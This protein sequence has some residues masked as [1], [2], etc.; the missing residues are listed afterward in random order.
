M[1]NTAERIL[2]ELLENLLIRSALG[3]NIIP[4]PPHLAGKAPH[5][6][7]S[8]RVDYCYYHTRTSLKQRWLLTRDPAAHAQPIRH[9][10]ENKCCRT[11]QY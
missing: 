7:V 9:D 6:T 1:R 2:I 5:H 4:P 3:G 8:Y 10:F 11:H